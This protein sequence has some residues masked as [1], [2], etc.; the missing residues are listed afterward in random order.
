MHSN[1]K[2]NWNDWLDIQFEL[3]RANSFY[4]LYTHH[5]WWNEKIRQQ[6]I[7]NFILVGD[8]RKKNQITSIKIY[9]N[10]RQFNIVE[11]MRSIL[12][13]FPTHMYANDWLTKYWN[14][15][16]NEIRNL[17]Y[18]EYIEDIIFIILHTNNM[19]F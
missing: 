18:E 17:F 9:Y 16:K 7:E 15:W 5:N 19:V 6:F 13:E 1:P 14:Q 11:R 10:F 2:K 4:I 8:H 3:R 12:A